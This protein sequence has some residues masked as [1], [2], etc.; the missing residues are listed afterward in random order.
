MLMLVSRRKTD[1][2]ATKNGCAGLRPRSRQHVD[3]PFASPGPAGES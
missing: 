1:V 2:L 3:H